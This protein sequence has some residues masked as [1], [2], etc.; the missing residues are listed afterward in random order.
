MSE[1]FVRTIVVGMVFVVI[2][3]WLCVSYLTLGANEYGVSTAEIDSGNKI[4]FTEVENTLDT[5]NSTMTNIK[6]TFFGWEIIL[7]PVKFLNTIYDIIVTP[8]Q[9]IGNMAH[10]VLGVP[11]IIISA[12]WGLL[13]FGF[14]FGL[15]RLFKQGD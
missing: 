7:L 5:T 12:I 14:L 13:I 11:S 1:D 15:V 8:F 10:N 3:S 4:N 2:L 9:I 6:N